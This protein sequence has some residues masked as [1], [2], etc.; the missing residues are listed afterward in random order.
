MVSRAI[1]LPG[2]AALLAACGP[3]AAA[4][5]APA[6]AFA[7]PPAPSPRASDAPRPSPMLV[8]DFGAA[9][10]PSWRNYTYFPWSRKN[11][12]RRARGPAGEAIAHVVSDDAGSML[13]R[14]V[15]ADLARTPVATWRWK[16]PGPVPGA[17]ER[18][19]DGD[20]AAARVYFA[21]G[22][23]GQADLADAEAI[24]YI[25]GRKRRAGEMG[26]SPFS[27]RIGIVCLRAGAAGAGAWQ[28][29]RRDLEADY[30]AYFKKAP[31]GPVTAIAILTDTDQ[32]DGR[33]EAWY[34]PITMEAR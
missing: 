9:A 1:A 31:P 12:Y 25:W 32:T 30:R 16:V 22:L 2:L 14:A 6:V 5:E 26:A 11:D 15:K 8:G 10:W 4:L 18:G 20:D 21:W 34:G 23:A 29:E 17:D 3:A 28:A 27:P 7:A 24:G 33:A 13:I 19:D